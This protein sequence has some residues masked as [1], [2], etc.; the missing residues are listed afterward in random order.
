MSLLLRVRGF[1]LLKKQEKKLSQDRLDCL[2]RSF[3]NSCGP[4]RKRFHRGKNDK[5]LLCFLLL[6]LLF[7]HFGITKH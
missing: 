3:T 6:S 5:N 7:K 2:D 1:Y 4:Q